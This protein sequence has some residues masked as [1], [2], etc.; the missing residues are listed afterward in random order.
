MTRTDCYLN[1]E[2]R[3]LQSFFHLS[4]CLT[5]RDAI[6][7]VWEVQNQDLPSFSSHQELT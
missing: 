7:E 3:Y 5:L 2:A 6:G 1:Q 4:S